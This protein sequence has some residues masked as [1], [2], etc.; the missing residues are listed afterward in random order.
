[1]FDYN[2]LNMGCTLALDGC[3][4]PLVAAFYQRKVHG[5]QIRVNRLPVQASHQTS[6][7]M[8][9]AWRQL[10]FFSIPN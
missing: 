5:A 6:T 10:P 2:F 4:Q 9:L 8:Q 1:L 3:K 7:G